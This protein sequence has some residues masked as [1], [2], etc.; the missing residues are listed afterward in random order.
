[1][2][3]YWVGYGFTSSKQITGSAQ[4][5]IPL[6]LQ[7]V[8]IIPLLALSHFVVPESPRWLAAHGRIP[9]AREVLERLH[10]DPSTAEPGAS[11][12]DEE[13]DRIITSIADTVKSDGQFGSGRWV[14][15]WRLLGREDAIKSRRRLLISC[16]IQAFQQLG[17]INGQYSTVFS[18]WFMGLFTVGFQGAVWV[19]PAEI[20]PLRLRAKGTALSTAV[21][22]MCNYL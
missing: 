22:W 14:D 18:R 6:A 7:I 13:V 10:Y 3:A 17:G 16:A 9:E 2:L 12:R 1:M 8:F 19:Y 20:L 5:R 11:G 4:W 15:I 21:N